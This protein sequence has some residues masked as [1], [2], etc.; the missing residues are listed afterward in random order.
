MEK[1]LR[2]NG[3]EV[4]SD[5]KLEP[6]YAKSDEPSATFLD[7]FKTPNLRKNT[8]IQF[9]NFFTTG[10]IYFTLTFDDGDLIPGD[11]YLNALVSGAIEVPT[12]F[13][14]YF[15]LNY[16]GRKKPVVGLFLL[17][18]AAFTASF[19]ITN[20]QAKMAVTLLGKFGINC[21]Y[22]IIEIQAAEIYP[23]VLRS[24][25]W[26]SCSAVGSFGT[27]LAPILS[28]ELVDDTIL[29]L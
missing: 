22:S 5:L 28:H 4:P 26:G 8:L 13:L 25:G 27:I 17:I 29:F 21:V 16:F 15:V 11:I 24:T 12:F 2:T 7:M 9:F 1:A 6:T 23:T 3:Q 10:S 20:P 18:G 14:A 19:F